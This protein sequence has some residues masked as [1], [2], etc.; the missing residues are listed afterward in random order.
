MAFVIQTNQTWRLG[1][2]AKE[3]T[4]AEVDLLSLWNL[5]KLPLQRPC[6]DLL[7]DSIAMPKPSSHV[8]FVTTTL[9]VLALML[10]GIG[11]RTI[12][13]LEATKNQTAFEPVANPLIVPLMDRW[14]LMDEISDEIDDYFRVFREE[15]IR[16]VDGLMTEGWIETHPRIGSTV[17]EPWHHD[18]TRGYEK[19]HASLQTVRRYAK[20][21]VIP[22]GNSYTI[23]VQVFKELEDNPRPLN[24][25]VSGKMLRTDNALD[26]DLSENWAATNNDGWIVLGRDVSLEQR[27]L[28]NIQQRLS[29]TP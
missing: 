14:F 29:Q 21:R 28:R 18:S 10:C 27:I 16:S 22:T 26:T 24:S 9:M 2:C 25:P 3:C 20:V 11:C 19:I 5:F 23:D 12:Q 15:R 4:L 17:L 1:A 6:F 8:I 13:N 7:S